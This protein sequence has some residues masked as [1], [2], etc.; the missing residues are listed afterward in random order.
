[1][2]WD[3]GAP[4]GGEA[5]MSVP[6]IHCHKNH[7]TKM[8]VSDM[9]G[10]GCNECG[11]TKDEG[12]TFYSCRICDFDVCDTCARIQQQGGLQ[13]P[14]QQQQQ[15]QQQH[16]QDSAKADSTDVESG[17]HGERVTLLNRGIDKGA[18]ETWDEEEKAFHALEVSARK[19]AKC[20]LGF[21]VGLVVFMC[22]ALAWA[23]P[24]Q[25]R[26]HE[27]HGSLEESSLGIAHA[28]YRAHSG[29]LSIVS[30]ARP[31]RTT[32]TSNSSG[33]AG[34]TST[35][36]ADE[37]AADDGGSS[38]S[39]IA[40]APLSPRAIA[41]AKHT[42]TNASA[43][44]A[45]TKDEEDDGV[46]A[47][48]KSTTTQ[49][50]KQTPTNASTNLGSTKDEE[51]GGVAA[52]KKST[53]TT[54]ATTTEPTKMSSTTPTSST[55]TTEVP[56]TTTKTATS[57]IAST[58]TTT[59]STITRTTTTS[60]T[61]TTITTTTITTTQ[62]IP[63]PIL[64]FGESRAEVA[65]LMTEANQQLAV[66]HLVHAASEGSE[67]SPL[68]LLGA[69][70]DFQLETEDLPLS[71]NG[72]K[73]IP[74]SLAD[75]PRCAFDWNSFCCNPTDDPGGAWC[76]TEGPCR[77]ATYDRC[78]P[79]PPSMTVS[80]KGPAGTEIAKLQLTAG[81]TEQ[82][83]FA[84]DGP[85][86]L[87]L[88]GGSNNDKASAPLSLKG[89][90]CSEPTVDTSTPS[91]CTSDTGFCCPSEGSTSGIPW[92]S[93]RGDCGGKKWDYCVPADRNRAIFTVVS[94]L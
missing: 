77:E 7:L 35:T 37:G 8:F 92:C 38:P 84:G 41:K 78:E 32:E 36:K 51:V 66:V 90:I 16:F 18:P 93:T 27:P 45:S 5:S 59:S 79:R 24:H 58:F 86:A 72:C 22:T 85:K 49:E 47:N 88:I 39:A 29:A 62:P 10:Y 33:E 60:I 70:Y 71:V 3:Q 74:W 82:S 6:F 80:L 44:L 4:P 48:N 40:E 65:V 94:R 83:P 28:G 12:T 52:N 11:G 68:L 53:T 64:S 76:T 34:E 20:F 31:G 1:M 26:S 81:F 63:D 17:H 73:C 69:S 30:S 50:A 15:Q 2:G 91:R 89:C 87:K 13:K 54:E 75:K 42:P 57:T 19:Q 9:D 55:T 56:A 14:Q 23:S 43:T 67:P 21:S 61:T 25:S 46:A